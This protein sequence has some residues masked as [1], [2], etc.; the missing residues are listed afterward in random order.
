[1]AD[2][3]IDP[4]QKTSCETVESP[5]G[6][7]DIV[8]ACR[9]LAIAVGAAAALHTLPGYTQTVAA[10]AHASPTATANAPTDRWTQTVVYKDASWAEKKVTFADVAKLS[11]EEQTRTLQAITNPISKIQLAGFLKEAANREGSQYA[12]RKEAANREGSQYAERKEAANRE[13][14]QKA[15]KYVQNVENNESLLQNKD[16]AAYLAKLYKDPVLPQDLIARIEVLIQ[17]GG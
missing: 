11:P 6:K 13:Y 15:Y 17:V 10:N 3:N 14:I 7:M 9:K 1:M 8:L 12:E 5:R 4:I 2:P 16:V